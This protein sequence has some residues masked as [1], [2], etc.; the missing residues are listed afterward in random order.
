[1]SEPYVRSEEELS[2]F[3]L[4]TEI[5]G[6]LKICRCNQC[7]LTD[8]LPEELFLDTY[9]K[10]EEGPDFN[11]ASEFSPIFDLKKSI[12]MKRHNTDVCLTS[13]KVDEILCERL[14][15]NVD[16]WV[17]EAYQE[18]TSVGRKIPIN[19]QCLDFLRI[20]KIKVPARPQ[21]D[22][23]EYR[24]LGEN[25]YVE[26]DID[27]LSD[28]ISET[29]HLER[30]E[31]YNR[32]LLRC[33]KTRFLC[34]SMVLTEE[35]IGH[36]KSPFDS[37]VSSTLKNYY[38]GLTLL[39]Q[40]QMNTDHY[41]WVKSDKW[42]DSITNLGRWARETTVVA[43]GDISNLV[44][45]FEK[46]AHEFYTSLKL[47]NEDLWMREKNEPSIY[48]ENLKKYCLMLKLSA[49]MNEKFLTDVMFHHQAAVHDLGV[50]IQKIIERFV[51]FLKIFYFKVL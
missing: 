45:W 39:E 50:L 8:L 25:Y 4:L 28:G 12:L 7:Y 29:D 3:N 35:T 15:I 1:M 9:K 47:S 48:I 38:Q 5:I 17:P 44:K 19:S 20:Y 43:Q 41:E 14:G 23:T 2:S 33:M 27:L 32:R 51:N 40:G 18:Y 22:E 37:P 11:E 21:D 49:K 36:V 42:L 16:S 10:I 26:T 6:E 13:E 34:K 31:D 46:S 24:K 30:T